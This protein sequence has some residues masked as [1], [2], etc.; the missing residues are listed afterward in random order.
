[1]DPENQGRI[2]D[3]VENHGRESLVVVLG[4]TDP[5]SLEAAAETVTRGDPSYVGPLAGVQLG[6]PVLH[7]LEPEVK[8]QVDPDVYRREIGLVEMSADLDA[9]RNAMQ[10]L[11]A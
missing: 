4:A 1:M 6:L 2:S 5:G 3:I 9:I 11:R 8:D 7:I 10:R